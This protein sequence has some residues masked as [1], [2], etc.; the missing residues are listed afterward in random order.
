MLTF[1]QT[2]PDTD[3]HPTGCV[4]GGWLAGCGQL[5]RKAF[6]SQEETQSPA[7]KAGEVPGDD[8]QAGEHRPAGGV[9]V[10]G[11]ELG[12]LRFPLVGKV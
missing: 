2:F 11:A 4:C 10:R 9:R 6:H 5:K 8:K 1:A 12:M 7:G 3:D